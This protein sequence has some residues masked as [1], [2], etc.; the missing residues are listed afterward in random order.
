MK[1]KSPPPTTQTPLTLRFFGVPQM[2]GE[3]TAQ[4]LPASRAVQLLAFLAI[5]GMWQTRVDVAELLWPERPA[6]GAYSN[7]RN[8]LVRANAATPLAP[9]ESNSHA[10]RWLVA[11]DFSDY[12][13]AVQAQDHERVILLAQ[14]ELLYGLDADASEP[15]RRW[16]QAERDAVA[17]SWVGS[18]RALAEDASRPVEERAR[19]AARWAARCP[20]D[21]DAV[22]ARIRLARTHGQEDVASGLYREFATLLRRE[23]GVQPS[24][25]LERYAIERAGGGKRFAESPSASPSTTSSSA[26]PIT[27]SPAA[28]A[29]RLIGRRL[30]MLR[31]TELMADARERCIVITGPG[32]VGKST[33][34]AA[35]YAQYLPQ[36]PTRAVAIDASSAGNAREAI[37][38]IATRLLIDGLNRANNE[39]ELADTLRDGHYLLFI[40]GAEQADL[41]KPFSYLLGHCPNLRLVIA[42]RSVPEIDGERVFGIDGFPLPDVDETDAELLS[43]NDGVRCF[44]DTAASAGQPL[45][46]ATCGPLVAALV[47]HVDG[48]PL[49]L[50]LLAKLT[51]VMSL[52]ALV[53]SFAQVT[54]NSQAHAQTKLLGESS[55]LI[56]SFRRSWDTLSP[57]QQSAL[58]ALSIFPAPFDAAA[59]SAVAATD[60]PILVSLV[61]RS[62][63]RP[64]SD[65]G[66]SLHAGIRA[67][68]RSVCPY[69]DEVAHAYINHYSTRLARL[70]A[71]A[72]HT[73]VQP[74]KQFLRTEAEHLRLCWQLAVEHRAYPALTSMAQSLVLQIG[75]PDSPLDFG[76]RFCDAEAVLRDV[77][78][79]PFTLNAL[80]LTGASRHASSEGSFAYAANLA[81]DAVQMAFSAQNEFAICAALI[82][83]L[84][85]IGMLRRWEDAKPLLVQL[86]CHRRRFHNLDVLTRSYLLEAHF[87]LNCGVAENASKILDQLIEVNESRRDIEGKKLSLFNKAVLWDNLGEDEQMMR[88]L[89]QLL[90]PAGGA[91]TCANTMVSA[92]FMLIECYILRGETQQARAHV[93]TLDS[94][95]KRVQ[96]HWTSQLEVE[97]ALALV[98]TSEGL[99]EHAGKRFARLL[100]AVANEKLP[101]WA[102]SVMHSAAVWFRRMGD[103]DT[104]FQLLR[105]SFSA[106]GSPRIRDA[107]ER[108][109]AE[110]GDVGRASTVVDETVAPVT[111]SVVAARARRRL[112]SLL[113]TLQ[114]DGSPAQ[115][116][117]RNC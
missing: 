78:H 108:M 76:H 109:L 93:G 114:P 55:P 75:L 35:L 84:W 100:E 89:K 47:H 7:L 106:F 50:K 90:A 20:Y 70:Y 27:A 57:A 83:Q 66:L 17:A 13:T 87:E 94:L 49:A 71:T 29:S 39:Q 62:L 37:A 104:C 21:E 8:L 112:L 30:E 1:S 115:N 77:D 25:E 72:Q 59:A 5:K 82:G 107:A 97:S 34:M 85:S 43:L 19:L 64:M 92:S 101:S 45:D 23:F 74:Y 51:R 22:Y 32:G 96:L 86:R 69:P 56:A 38:T 28:R 41:A 117:P 6:K 81:Q 91:M 99:L 36:A 61:D 26:T 105:A 18:V 31:L 58:T 48:L 2:L 102:S 60:L 3:G 65:Q 14:D 88:S 42:S 10:I 110:L 4:P 80:L 53:E 63:V 40:D 44:M 11:S 111:P 16:L 52:A 24:R 46:L 116:R 103:N 54:S 95:A 67:C 113:A 12:A 73:N 68:V 79:V 9:V 98:E 15:W 33:L